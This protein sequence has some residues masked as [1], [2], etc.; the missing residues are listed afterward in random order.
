MATLDTTITPRTIQDYDGVDQDTKEITGNIS[1]GSLTNGEEVLSCSSTES[2]AN[3]Q[4][5]YETYLSGLGY[6]WT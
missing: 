3:V 5:A 2:D 1:D 6:T 4:T